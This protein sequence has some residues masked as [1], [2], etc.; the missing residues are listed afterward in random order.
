M[1]ARGGLDARKRKIF[2]CFVSTRPDTHTHTDT[3]IR[4]KVFIFAGGYSNCWT[5]R[6]RVVVTEDVR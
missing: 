2:H 4:I 3:G 1:C 6:T 5:E